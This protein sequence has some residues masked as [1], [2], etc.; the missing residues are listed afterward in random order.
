MAAG[1]AAGRVPSTRPVGQ[2]RV[3]QAAGVKRQ[4]QEANRRTCE[5][6]EQDGRDLSVICRWSA[7]TVNG[8]PSRPL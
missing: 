5:E 8:P 4:P 2:D 6:W 3:E 1:S 7:A